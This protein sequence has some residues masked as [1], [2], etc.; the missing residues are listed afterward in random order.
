VAE[1]KVYHTIEPVYFKDSKILILG[2]MPS[3]SSRE[4]NF[5]YAHPQNR[6]WKVLSNVYDEDIPQSIESKKDFLKRHN[7]ALFDVV[8][9]CTI[10][11]SSDSSIKNVEVNDIESILKTTNISKI[12]TAGKTAHN[13]Y[14]KY[15][16]NKLNKEAICLPSTSPANAK[17]SYDD[18]LKEYSVIK[19]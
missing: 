12:Y 6:F 9:S 1:E 7:I 18:L 11:G 5:Y 8:K 19:K 10:K 14:N 3:V 17:I 15:L 4:N 2:S 13:L 16:K